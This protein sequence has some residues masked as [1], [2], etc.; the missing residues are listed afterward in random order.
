MLENKQSTNNQNIIED[1]NRNIKRYYINLIRH[2]LENKNNSINKI[3]IKFCDYYAI[4][5]NKYINHNIVDKLDEDE[6][7]KLKVQIIKDIQNFITIITVAFKVILFKS[8]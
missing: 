1:D 5:L 4:E 8:Y 2:Q 3:I 6:K 7:K